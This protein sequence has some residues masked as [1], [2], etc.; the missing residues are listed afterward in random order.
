MKNPTHYWAAGILLAFAYLLI[1]SLMSAW[2]ENVLLREKLADNRLW[3][4]CAPPV[5]NQVLIVTP[6]WRREGSIPRYD[7]ECVYRR[8]GRVKEWK[9]RDLNVSV[10]SC[11]VGI[12]L[13]QG[14]HLSLCN[15]TNGEAP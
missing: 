3:T 14:W 12:G 9:R 1:H 4:A 8:D 15:I 11:P 7:Y 10:R 13:P 6:A 5:A 2:D